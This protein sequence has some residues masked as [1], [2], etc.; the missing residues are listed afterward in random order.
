[1]NK[2]Y[3]T[4][5]NEIDLT[6]QKFSKLTV[7]GKTNNKKLRK[8]WDCI[9]DC[10]NKT[11]TSGDSLRV[12]TTRSCGCLRRFPPYRLKD[13]KLAIFK[14]LYAKKIKKRS[15]LIKKEGNLPFEIFCHLV[16]SPCFYCGNPHSQE[17]RDVS[18]YK[19]EINEISSEVLLHNGIDR[20]DS[21]KGYVSGNCR[22]CCSRCNFAKSDLSE[23]LFLEHITKIYNKSCKI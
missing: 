15:K 5:T 10:G 19:G 11:T 9:C 1:M 8:Y 17:T 12:G 20:I 22:S 13:R 21:E 7:L 23:Q 18:Y 4:G 3:I 2:K 14:N 16:V 6:G